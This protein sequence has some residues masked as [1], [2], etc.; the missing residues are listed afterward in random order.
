MSRLGV[1]AALVGGTLVRGDV[2]VVDGLVSRV[3]VSPSVGAAVAVPGL[4]DLQVN[5]VA[6]V[7]L[8]VADREGYEVAGRLLAGCGATAVQP[9]FHS[10]DLDAHCRSLARLNEVLADPPRGTRWLPAHMEGPFLATSRRGAHDPRHLLAC[11]D[12]ALDRLLASGP[13]A[14]MTIAPEL[15]G[16]QEIIRR[17]VGAGVVVSVGHTDAAHDQ[18]S[19]A[20]DAGARHIT[21]C[22][23]AMRP[24]SARDPGP[25]GAA[26]SDP[27]LT[28]GVIADLVHVSGPVLALTAAAA[29]KRLAATTDSV[30][31]AACNAVD[32]EVRTADGVLAGGIGT[33]DGC[34]RNL[35][36]VGVS[37]ADAV[38]ACGGA[39]R[40]LLG[41]TPVRLLPGEQAELVLL[42]EALEPLRT[43]VDGRWYEPT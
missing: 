38:D 43:M 13:V 4:V 11:D 12:W 15:D 18:V 23:N 10:Q 37:L 21:H 35:V 8:R 25:V 3:G 27:R 36:R 26:L 20:V 42:D 33:P 14:L 2:E 9:T 41:L 19:A 28:V 22:W 40:R 6:G 7:D 29:R 5:G 30:A 24:I 31:S 17:L 32:S 39:Q 1:A 34:L 16:S